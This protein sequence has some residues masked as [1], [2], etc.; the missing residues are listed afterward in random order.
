MVKFS[1]T[2][3]IIIILAII[4][5][6]EPKDQTGEIDI[7]NVII[8]NLVFIPAYSLSRPW[9][10]ITS[11]FL[12]A[13]ITHILFNSLGLFF[14]GVY[15]EQRVSKYQYILIFLLAGII[16]NVGYTLTTSDPTIPGLGASGAIY[17]I[18]GTVAA[19]DPLATVY[20]GFVPMPM[21]VAAFFWGFSE[22]IGLFTPSD[23]AHGAH[24]FGLF[25]GLIIGAY[26][27]SKRKK[28][29]A[30]SF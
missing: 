5:L 29:V 25:F 6:L 7:S 15:F 16:G 22:F 21:I 4:F 18:L 14:F 17:G 9:T 3:G 30:F 24:I 23:V 19:L 1:I 10:F 12:H 28:K 13:D 11:I 2:V 8:Q 26:Y 27:R 20:M